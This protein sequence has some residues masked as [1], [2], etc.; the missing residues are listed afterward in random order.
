M[1]TYNLIKKLD[2]LGLLNE[3]IK[4]GVISFN[5]VTWLELHDFYINELTLVKSRMQVI[6]NTA[7]KFGYSE[8]RTREI[9]NFIRS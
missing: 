5:Y 1:V 3:C 6:T 9:I 7:T 8:R 4:K 2:S